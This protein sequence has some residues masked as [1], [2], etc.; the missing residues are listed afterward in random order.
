V[1]AVAEN[2]DEFKINARVDAIVGSSSTTKILGLLF[3]GIVI[4]WNEKSIRT[5]SRAGD[6]LE[7]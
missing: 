4:L 7:L 1:K 5:G 6:A 3:V 2:P